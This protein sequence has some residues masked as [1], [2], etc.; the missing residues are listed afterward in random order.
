MSAWS[1][2][3]SHHR[4]R[5]CR[6]LAVARGQG[7]RR[8]AVV[9]R[10]LDTRITHLLPLRTLRNW[11]RRGWP[12]PRIQWCDYRWQAYRPNITRTLTHILTPTHTYTCIRNSRRSKRQPQLRR[13]L[14]LASHYL[15]VG[16]H[17]RA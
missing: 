7:N 11:R 16:I 15:E 2:W 13:R 1:D 3:A 17:D 8:P 10:H 5:L 6:S 14:Q 12:W 4:N 9:D